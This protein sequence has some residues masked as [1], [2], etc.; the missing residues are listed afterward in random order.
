MS[1][2]KNSEAVKEVKLT[3]A[4]KKEAKIAAAREIVFENEVDQ[5]KPEKETSEKIFSSKF[6]DFEMETSKEEPEISPS[7]QISEDRKF[8]EISELRGKV[9]IPSQVGQTY[10]GIW[11]TKEGRTI[12][13]F[14]SKTIELFSVQN[15]EIQ[16]IPMNVVLEN[17]LKSCVEKYGSEFHFLQITYLG[18]TK[19][20]SNT[21]ND[22]RLEM[23]ASTDIEIAS[24]G[25]YEM[26]QS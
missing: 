15:N 4:Q 26:S 23:S 10:Q 16:L 1:T 8:A 3:A 11:T 25:R 24:L 22:W 6:E 20:N 12:G 2:L 17:K 21:Y 14:D 18:K 5:E 13:E 9:C 7:Q 19:G